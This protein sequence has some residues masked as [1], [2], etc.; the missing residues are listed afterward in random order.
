MIMRPI[1]WKRYFL[2]MVGSQDYATDLLEEIFFA[3]GRVAECC[4]LMVKRVALH[5]RR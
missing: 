4:D 5:V 3:D 2:P 1:Y